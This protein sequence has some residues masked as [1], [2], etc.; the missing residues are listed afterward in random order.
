MDA[1]K[2]LVEWLKVNRPHLHAELQV[3]GSPRELLNQE[4]GLNVSP[5]EL[6]GESSRAYLEAF[7]AQ[8]EAPRNL[9][10]GDFIEITDHCAFARGLIGEVV[11]VDDVGVPLV[12]LE[13]FPG[14]SDQWW[15]YTGYKRLAT[16]KTFEGV[17]VRDVVEVVSVRAQGVVQQIHWAADRYEAVVLRDGCSGWFSFDQLRVIDRPS[18]TKAVP[19][20]ETVALIGGGGGGGSG[21]LSGTVGTSGPVVFRS[22]PRFQSMDET[23]A[24]G[25]AAERARI[26]A[27][28]KQF[29][30]GELAVEYSRSIFRA[31]QNAVRKHHAKIV[32]SITSPD[33]GVR[34]ESL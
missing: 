18:Q 25:A 7:I 32:A 27:V 28:L 1:R 20:G 34:K 30:E 33:D 13:A 6:V 21:H 22:P 26:L 2:Q 3:S 12:Q 8:G 19:A 11:R 16:P 10:A 14:R 9:K 4:T 23:R 31:E 24:E 15:L 5:L 17:Q 29:E